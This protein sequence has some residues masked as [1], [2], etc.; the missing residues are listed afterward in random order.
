MTGRR[1]WAG[2]GVACALAIAALAPPAAAF[3]SR[4][5]QSVAVTEAIQDDL[6]AAGG[7]VAVNAPVEGDVVAAGGSVDMGGDVGGGV[8]AAGGKATV[9]GAVG[10]S[11]R[12]AA[13]SLTLASRVK[14]DAVLAGGEVHVTPAAQIGRD[15]GLDDIQKLAEFHR[16][17]TL[18]ELA[19]DTT[20]LQV[21]SG[22]Q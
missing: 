5:G 15:L 20:G 6:Y 18:V 2:T 7:R 4:S 17:M 16:T 11:V 22:K 8:L 19:D 21:Q 10:R 14:G 9:S 13:G 1:R 12:A 3:V